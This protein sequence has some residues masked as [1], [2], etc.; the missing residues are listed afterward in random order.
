MLKPRQICMLSQFIRFV[1]AFPLGIEKERIPNFATCM[2]MNCRLSCFWRNWLILFHLDME[3]AARELW[4]RKL[5]KSFACWAMQKATEI[6]KLQKWMLVLRTDVEKLLWCF[7]FLLEVST[8]VFW[9]RF[10]AQLFDGHCNFLQLLIT[11]EAGWHRHRGA[12]LRRRGPTNYHWRKKFSVTM[13]K[14]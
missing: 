10:P 7:E 6:V 2:A 3:A 1:Q 9:R 8:T 13:I 12:F 4:F 5:C 11:C 14:Q